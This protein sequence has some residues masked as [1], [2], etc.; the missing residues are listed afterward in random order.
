MTLFI[1]S[2]NSSS[3]SLASK[4][5]VTECRVS[6]PSP[7][8]DKTTSTSTGA[9]SPSSETCSGETCSSGRRSPVSPL[10]ASP[11]GEENA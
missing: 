8:F 7:T 6:G 9:H 11:W 5:A 10:N 3:L 2:V 4:S 1:T